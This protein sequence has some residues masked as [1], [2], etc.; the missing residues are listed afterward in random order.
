[1][2]ERIHAGSKSPYPRGGT[3]GLLPCQDR[4]FVELLQYRTKDQRWGEQ[5][6]EPQAERLVSVYHKTKVPC[7][8][9]LLRDIFPSWASNGSCVE[10]ISK[11]FKEIVFDS[12]DHFVP[13][14]ILR[15]NP[16]PEYYNMEVKRLKAKAR[17]V[18]NK[19]KLDAW[20]KMELNRL[21]KQLL[22]A[23]KTAEETFLRLVLH[24]AGEG[25]G[26]RWRNWMRHC[27]TN[28]KDA[29]SIPNGVTGIF[30]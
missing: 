6:R 18:H 7:L 15:K 14:K 16:D 10:D 28:R 11:R 22:A 30:Q 21:S 1:M 24:T 4:K 26:T 9:S 5:C 8:Q 12:I 29:G 23:K 27:A 3:A 13:H 17:R 25:E 20:H 2:G 19:R